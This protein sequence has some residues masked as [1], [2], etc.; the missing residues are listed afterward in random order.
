MHMLQIEA[1]ATISVD[2]ETTALTPYSQSVNI[3]KQIKFG[4]LGR[5]AYF[6]AGKKRRPHTS[7]I[8]SLLGR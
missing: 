1:A 3:T 7:F 4:E 2:L 5:D 8:T 6:A